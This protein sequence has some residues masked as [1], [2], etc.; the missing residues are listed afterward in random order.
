MS[1]LPELT[2]S[3]QDDEQAAWPDVRS[4]SNA[5]AAEVYAKAGVPVVPVCPGT[6]NPGSYLGLGWPQRATTDLDTIRDWWRRWPDAG[7]AMHPGG[8]G[9][10]VLD[11]DAPEHVPEW[12]WGHLERAVFRRTTADPNNRRGHYIWR[13]RPGER[14]G[15]SLGK[16]KSPRGSEVWGQV[17]CYGGAVVLAPTTHPTEGHAYT[18]GPSEPIPLLPDEIA[19]KLS[20]APDPAE[21]RTLTPSELDTNAEA[22]L[23]T[24]AD[25]REPYALAPILADFDPA[26]GGRHESMWNAVCWAL[27]E[28]KA[29]RFPA[30]HAVG[31]L[32]T[33]WE[34]AI[35][36]EHRNGDTDEFERMVR[37]GVPVADEDSAEG[38]WAR[39]HRNRWPNPGQPQ[40]VAQEVVTRAKQDCRPIAYWRGDWFR[41]DR[42][43]WYPT[44]EDQIRQQLYRQLEHA[45]YEKI[46]ANGIRIEIAWNPDKAKLT[47]VIDA[48]KAE[49]LWPDDVEE[50]TWRDG[51]TCRVLPFINGLLRI[52]DRVLMPHTP[53]YFNTECIDC[54][55]EPDVKL[56]AG[57][58]FLNDLT[59]NDPEAIETLMEFVGT[60]LVGDDRFQKMLV[61]VGPSGSG[62]GT[63]DRLLSRML[64]RKHAGVRMDDY[65]NN[66]F[67]IE[68]LLGKTLVTFSDQRVQLDMKRFTDLL[69]Q[70]VGGDAI[71]VRRPYDRRSVSVR[72]PL[73]FIMLSNEAPVLPDNAGA[74]R[75]RLL[76][77]VTPNSFADNADYDLDDKLTA[78]LPAFVDLALA[79]YRRLVKRGRFVQP[80]SGQEILTVIRENASY[81]A[82]FID[83]CCHVGPDLM[84]PKDDLYTRWKAWCQKNGHTAT[85]ANKFAGDLYSLPLPGGHKITQTKR[86]VDG[87][88]V[89]C[90]R[91]V[92]LRCGNTSGVKL[93]VVP[94]D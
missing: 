48:L 31:E 66:G 77:I 86:T 37:D 49:T 4:M 14:F 39:A 65:K 72:L 63:F 43:C 71:S 21:S 41:W 70:V 83:E 25:N 81:L 67:P 68:P 38:L 78:E 46:A 54:D 6:K 8:A 79:A 88:R 26:P 17:R 29:G 34:A 92:A 40:R 94:S 75:R 89:P 20:A 55:Y 42:R 91:G 69:L 28:A 30:R 62:K 13:L 47:N 57:Q 11:V 12:L 44:S 73:T 64:G 16:L 85:A 18:S 74:M 33:I 19:A 87:D 3:G 27:R 32:R 9:L 80:E 53:D 10:L 1:T 7:I 59:G 90:F 52:D 5:D 23:D 51:R 84:E 24:Y 2:N 82:S 45:N 56:V 93:R 50:G 61:I 22:F 58:K 35:G 36:G 76:A 15:C 60:R